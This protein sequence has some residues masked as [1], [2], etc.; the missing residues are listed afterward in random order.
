[1]EAIAEIT[2]RFVFARLTQVV[3][4]SN[5][6]PEELGIEITNLLSSRESMIFVSRVMSVRQQNNNFF[7]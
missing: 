2:G 6:N 7:M 4:V 1:V 3:P 5:A